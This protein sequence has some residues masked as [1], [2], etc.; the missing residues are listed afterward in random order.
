MI[1]VIFLLLF[2]AFVGVAF[3]VKLL[4]IANRANKSVE[5][6]LESKP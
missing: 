4:R 3:V 6:W 2:F 1:A 5:K